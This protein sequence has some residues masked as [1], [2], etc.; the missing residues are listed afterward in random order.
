MKTSVD[1]YTHIVRFCKKCKSRNIFQIRDHI[2]CGKLV[3]GS[4]QDEKDS[5]T[6][7]TKKG[8]FFTCLI[9]DEF[10]LWVQSEENKRYILKI[11]ARNKRWNQWK[12]DNA[13]FVKKMEDE[14]HKI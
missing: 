4:I 7:L 2:S 5:S 9:C 14:G 11:K 1:Y 12:I 13:E 10:T 8:H 6:G 3:K